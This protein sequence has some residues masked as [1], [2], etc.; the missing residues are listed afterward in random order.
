MAKMTQLPSAQATNERW[1]YVGAALL[2][3]ALS[4]WSGYAQQIP[5]PDALYYLRAAEFFRDGQWQQGFA[6]YRWPFFSLMI[7]A[8]MA[9]TGA[10]AQVAALLID[11]LFDSAVVV[12][13]IALAR[14]LA[15]GAGARQIVGWAAFVIV[16]HPKLAVMRS[17]IVRDHGYYAFVLS[18]L[19]LVVRDHQEP[20]RWLKPAIAG[21]IAIAALFRLEALLFAVMVPAFYLA[22]GRSSGGR[23]LLVVAAILLLGLLMAVV[24]AAWTGAG[25]PAGQIDFDILARFRD[26]TDTLRVRAARLSEAVPPIRNAGLLAY[27]GFSVAALVDA[28][29][30]A[31]TIPLAILAVF[32]F[33]P[34]RL[35]SD[36]AARFVVWFCGSQLVLLLGFV[37]TSFFIDWRFA[38]LFALLMTIPA[39]FT[40]AEVAEEWRARLPG[41][42]L[43]MPIVLLAV[44]VP[45]IVEFPRFSKLEHLRQA[46]QWIGSNVPAHAKVLTNDGRIAYFSG[47]AF[48]GEILL[49]MVA[50]TTDRAVREV[51][52]VAVEAARNAPPAFVTR[53][54][55]VATI[56]GANN[57]SVFIYKTK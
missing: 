54:R 38:M 16:L 19:Y 21:C 5:N 9:L 55:L 39:I 51:D 27:L 28:V 34:R 30:R 52:Y 20:Q 8:V 47:R 31:A 33:T 57:R 22:T 25:P 46:G 42:R 2:S 50:D 45:W 7:A 23:K 18:A 13:L 26:I 1:I 29:L 36:F 14:R 48:P 3:L 41:S 37:L 49:L 4:A 44:V 11:A 24:Y 6:V 43:L 17:A 15:S 35:L 56:D 32:A 10:T 40:V 12:L 53:D